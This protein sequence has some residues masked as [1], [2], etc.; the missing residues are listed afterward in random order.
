MD[1]LKKIIELEVQI[2]E[3]QKALAAPGISEAIQVAMIAHQ[4]SIRQQI[5][6]MLKLVR[7]AP[8]KKIVKYFDEDGDLQ[9]MYTDRD[10]FKGWLS[11]VSSLVTAMPGSSEQEIQ[12]FDVINEATLYRLK[13]HPVNLK[14]CVHHLVATQEFE[15]GKAC[16]ALVLRDF[17]DFQVVKATA[18]SE[19]G[20]GPSANPYAHRIDARVEIDFYAKHGKNAIAGMFQLT[21]PRE[22]KIKNFL[23]NCDALHPPAN[24]RIVGV[25][26]AN[27]VALEQLQKRF[28]AVLVRSATGFCR[29]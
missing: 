13:H 11:D 22:K 16:E 19:A 8:D 1:P 24:T 26:L 17:P 20:K 10:A 3:L 28:Y 4:G 7:I 5:A 12:D 9:H 2:A 21:M 18:R 6:E 25:S 14:A 23:E 27:P 29:L 15:F